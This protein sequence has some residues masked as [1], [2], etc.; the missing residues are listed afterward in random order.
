[1]SAG[2]Q[3]GSQ[4]GS[5][6]YVTVAIEAE[7]RDRLSNL[8][9]EQN[10]SKSGMLRHMIICAERGVPAAERYNQKYEEATA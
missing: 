2:T 9:R 8:A 7:Y 1:M 6:G 5:R 10:R 4:G 3:G